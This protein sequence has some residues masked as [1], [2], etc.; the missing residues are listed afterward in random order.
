MDNVTY[1]CK[2]CIF[3][4]LISGGLD[5]DTCDFYNKP[6]QR[7]DIIMGR[8]CKE[9]RLREEGMHIEDFLPDKAVEKARYKKEIKMYIIAASVL[10]FLGIFVLTIL[11]SP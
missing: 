9:F 5:K 7:K 11:T 3:Y 10:V 4:A 6:L 1:T 2:D 8:E